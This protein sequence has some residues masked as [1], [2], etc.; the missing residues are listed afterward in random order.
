ME[1]VNKEEQV[2]DPNLTGFEDTGE[3]D[4]FGEVELEE[5]IKAPETETVTDDLKDK[6][7]DNVTD[8]DKKALAKEQEEETKAE[9]E[10]LGNEA[11][12]EINI[13]D[14]EEETTDDK[15]EDKEDEEDKEPDLF[16]T[17]KLETELEKESSIKTS[18]KSIDWKKVAD[19]IDLP[20]DLKIN[21]KEETI[22]GFKE[23]VK[24]S[25][26][27]ARQ[28]V[29]FDMEQFNDDQKEVINYFLNDGSK[30]DLLNPLKEIDDVLLQPSED[31]VMEYL[32]GVDGLNKEAAQEKINDMIENDT[33]DAKVTSIN[34]ELYSL[35]ETRY[36]EIIG[37]VTD[38]QKQRTENIIKENKAMSAHIDDM[39]EFMGMKL[40][41]N[42]KSY[43]KKE[44]E[45][46]KLAKA[47]NNAESQIVARLF[48]LY[49]NQILKQIQ[50]GA[51]NASRE[52]YNKGLEKE[53]KKIHNIPPK[54]QAQTAIKQKDNSSG[55]VDPLALFQNIEADSIDLE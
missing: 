33:L 10:K 12:E 49:G 53:K 11:E 35:R 31:K 45:T 17:S 41:D 24:A 36:K 1:K 7:P 8:K 6:E 34:N 42:V 47:N 27:N 55:I 3:V 26:E 9:A 30:A 20:E 13:F 54:K 23:A 21:L 52:S 39:S 48:A 25:I 29:A 2:N 19:A 32:I 44:I 22:D 4:S 43:I 50:E 51:K 40:P 28:K 38:K 16:D 46:G 5:E 18:S 15:E 37:S 14:K